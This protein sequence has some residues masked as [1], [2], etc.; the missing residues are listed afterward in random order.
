MPV[1]EYLLYIV[2]FAEHRR[3]QGRGNCAC[4]PNVYLPGFQRTGSTA[5]FSLIARL[6]GARATDAPESHVWAKVR[7]RND[8]LI[9]ARDPYSL[10]FDKFPL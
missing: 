6:P 1:S 7:K 3:A 10:F 5:L 9:S 8:P 4:L 2:H